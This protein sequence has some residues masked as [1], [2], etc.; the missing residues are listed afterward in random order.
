MN[1]DTN[2]SIEKKSKSAQS[3]IV[4]ALA[5]AI[6]FMSIGFATYAATLNIGGAGNNAQVTVKKAKWSVHWVNGG[7]SDFVASTGSQPFATSSVT[8]TDVSFTTTLNK[9]GDFAEFTVQATNDGTFDAVLTGVTLG[10]VS[11]AQD[12]YIDYSL[13]Y[14]NGTP[15][16]A[17]TSGLNIALDAGDTHDVVVRVEYV[18]PVSESALP[19]ESDVTLYL[20]ASLDYEQ[21]N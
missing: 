6:V 8:D 12:A 3:I 17:S 10:G 21:A 13:T 2:T 11:A 16:T 9:P 4:Y 19:T 1:M 14:N 15:Y 5:A 7:S 20:T 18:Q